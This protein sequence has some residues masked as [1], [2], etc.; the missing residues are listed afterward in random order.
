MGRYSTEDLLMTNH[1]W[2]KLSYTMIDA[3]VINGEIVTTISDT[4]AEVAEDEAKV[5]CWFCDTPL[6]IE[7]INTECVPEVAPAN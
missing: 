2:V 1:L 3:T 4:S 7:T 5:G 6:D